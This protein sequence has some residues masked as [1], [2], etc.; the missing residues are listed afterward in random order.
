MTGLSNEPTKPAATRKTKAKWATPAMT[1][2]EAGDAEQGGGPMNDG[3]DGS[4]A[5]S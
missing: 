3:Y 1:R 5:F 2:L 4:A